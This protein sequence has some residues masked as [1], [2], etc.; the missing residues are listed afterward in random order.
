MD[1]DL[2]VFPEEKDDTTKKGWLKKAK[3]I[4]RNVDG[5]TME[6]WITKFPAQCLYISVQAWFTEK[7]ETVFTSAKGRK[8]IL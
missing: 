5:P 7:I 3:N 1:L 8:K 2:P 4:V 6:A